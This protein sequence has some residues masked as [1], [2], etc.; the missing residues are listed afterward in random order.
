MTSTSL[1]LPRILFKSLLIFSEYGLD[2]G[3]VDILELT[4]SQEMALYRD[5]PNII[6]SRPSV[7]STGTGHVMPVVQL[8]ITKMCREI[9]EVQKPSPPVYLFQNSVVY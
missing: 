7:A 5:T 8:A 3:S 9:H 4:V 6:S 1:L 2:F